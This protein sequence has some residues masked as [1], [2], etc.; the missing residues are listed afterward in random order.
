VPPGQARPEHHNAVRNAVQ[1]SL[2]QEE[3]G[4]EPGRRRDAS[5]RVGAGVQHS[6]GRGSWT[7][8]DWNGKD[9]LRLSTWPRFSKSGTKRSLPVRERQEVQEV[10]R[11]CDITQ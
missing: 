3:P 8:S 2:L 1:P 6:G 5:T 9:R 7:L 11:G 4:D 10:S